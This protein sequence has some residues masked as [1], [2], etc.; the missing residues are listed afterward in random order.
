MTYDIKKIFS[1]IA[2]TAISLS[3]MATDYSDTLA[4][5]VNGQTIYKNATITLSEKESGTYTLTLKNL[6]AGTD[7]LGTITFD[8]C[9]A[10]QTDRGMIFDENIT[11]TIADGDN[12]RGITW[13][14][15]SLGDINFSLRASLADNKLQAV[16]VF[17]TTGASPKTYSLR[18]G[19]GIH[20]Y[21]GS[22]ETFKFSNGIEV[23]DEGDNIEPEYWHSFNTASGNLASFAGKH[24]DL[25]KD[26]RV[27]SS[28]KKSLRLYSTKI[29]GIVANGTATNGR[30][31]AGSMSAENVANHAQTN[32]SDTN[33]DSIGHPFYTRL[34]VQPDSIALW[35]KFKQGTAN[36]QHPY[37]TV[38][39][40]ITDGTY[41]QDPEDKIYTNKVAVAKNNTIATNG[42]AW[43]RLSIPFDYATYASNNA[44]QKAI[45]ITMSTNADPGQGS[46]ND[47]LYVDDMELIYNAD[48][49]SVK[50]SG[51]NIEAAA[52]AGENPLP[53]YASLKIAQVE[54][55]DAVAASDFTVETNARQPFVYKEVVD[56]DDIILNDPTLPKNADQIATIVCYAADLSKANAWMVF[57]NKERMAGDVNSDGKTDISDVTAMIDIILGKDNTKPY[58]YDHKAADMDENGTIDISDVTSLIDVILGKQN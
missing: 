7:A 14:G 41:Y 12:I 38:T 46:K 9:Y 5:T 52:Y 15:P 22:F 35:A 3:A 23:E 1:L 33:T 37:A 2:L 24:C 16:I 25:S 8:D 31:N 28:S 51:E 4:V 57:I 21:N 48:I 11:T 20:L 55:K 47:E 32:I 56:A 36:A 10:K 40:T 54:V 18:F 42:A 39:A 17:T 19:D 53:G 29:L 26:T 49:T 34:N 30:L 13:T 27:N 6:I 50:L 58:T 43:Q 44:E 45:L